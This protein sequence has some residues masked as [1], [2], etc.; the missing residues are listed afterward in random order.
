MK[1]SKNRE[2]STAIDF[3]KGYKG[4]LISDFFSAYDNVECLQQKCWVHFIRDLNNNLWDNPFDKE[5][6]NFVSKIRNLI[7]PI[8]Q[9]ADQYGLKKHFLKKYQ[10]PINNFYKQDIDNKV[11]KSEPCI[12]YQKRF[13]R[14]R[15]SLFTFINHN[16]INWHNNAAENGLRHICIQRKISGSF[17]GNQF[18]HYLRMASIL[19]TCKLQKKSFF[20]FLLSKEKDIDIFSGKRK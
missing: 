15:N 17:G 20:K 1:L 7:V 12:L 8:I 18:P 6:E 10:K 14:Y 5:Y 19:Q 16:E 4:V 9:T 2:A 3:L 11:Y 13:I